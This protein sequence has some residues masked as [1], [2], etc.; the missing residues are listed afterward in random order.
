MIINVDVQH[1]D[2]RQRV[3]R[4]SVDCAVDQGSRATEGSSTI[5]TTPVQDLPYSPLLEP[6]QEASWEAS[7]L[8][9]QNGRV[10]RPGAPRRPPRPGSSGRPKSAHFVG[11][12]I[13]LPVGTKFATFWTKFGHFWTLFGPPKKYV[14]PHQ[15]PKKRSKMAKIR[16]SG[17]TAR[18]TEICTFLGGR[19]NRPKIAIFQGWPKKC[20]NRPFSGKTR[21]W[22]KKGLQKGCP[23]GL[24]EGA[25]QG[26]SREV[27][28]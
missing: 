23:G 25:I 2:E 9:S 28:R 3:E 10:G 6:S 8:T 15:G 22:P 4:D 13:T 11:Y 24:L 19:Q 16:K 26:V 5:G 27:T 21:F 7:W 14:F 12:L 18:D 1:R 17:R 20:Q